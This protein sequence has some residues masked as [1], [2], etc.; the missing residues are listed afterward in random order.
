MEG[1]L[2][3]LLAF[4]LYNYGKDTFGHFFHSAKGL[5]KF[6][7]IMLIVFFVLSNCG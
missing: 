5:F 4:V 3:L 7:L 1:I 6:F 2:V